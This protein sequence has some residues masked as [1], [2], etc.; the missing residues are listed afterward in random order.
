M[1]AVINHNYNRKFAALKKTITP[2]KHGQTKIKK[3]KIYVQFGEKKCLHDVS[4]KINKNKQTIHD[5][6]CDA[7]HAKK[8]KFFLF[9]HNFLNLM[10]CLK[11]IIFTTIPSTGYI[12]SRFSLMFCSVC[13][14]QKIIC[15]Q[16]KIEK[17]RDCLYSNIGT[18]TD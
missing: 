16:F 3:M 8:A 11:K 15:K 6:A 13:K 12:F 7:A 5:Y 2:D 17:K 18:G 10:K 1:V 4:N 14:L 9:C